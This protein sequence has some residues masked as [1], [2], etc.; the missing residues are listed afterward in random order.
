MSFIIEP[1]VEE[2]AE[3]HSSPDGELFERLAAETR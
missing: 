2:Y 3:A 1:T